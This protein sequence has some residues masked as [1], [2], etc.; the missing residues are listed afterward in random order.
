MTNK[1]LF[2]K[3]IDL[4]RERQNKKF[5]NQQKQ[6]DVSLYQW[7]TILGEEYGEFLKEV[8]DHENLKAIIELAETAAVCLR[9][10]EVFFSNEVL[11]EAFDIM[12]KRT[13]NQKAKE[14]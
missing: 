3:L 5:P 9:I 7:A 12:N 1:E 4:E 11:K 8:N 10:S 2:N 6:K 13:Q 14:Q